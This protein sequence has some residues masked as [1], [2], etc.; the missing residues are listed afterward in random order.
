ME[1]RVKQPCLGARRVLKASQ[2]TC[3][4][5][6]RSLCGP[7]G[8]LAER[9]QRLTVCGVGTVLDSAGVTQ[10]MDGTSRVT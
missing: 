6:P 5:G 10:A 7:R 3:D 4:P 8:G 9:G 1:F 2:S